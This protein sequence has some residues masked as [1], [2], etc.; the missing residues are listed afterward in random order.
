MDRNGFALLGVLWMVAVVGSVLT[1]GLAPVL[2]QRDGAVNRAALVRA[3]WAAEGCIAL[4]QS[5]AADGR[6]LGAVDSI[7]LG[8]NVWCSLKSLRPDER[9]NVNRADS[10]TLAAALRDPI[11]VA[12]LLDWIDEDDIPREGGAEREWYIDRRRP[13]PRNAPFQDVS[14]VTKVRGFDGAG[15]DDLE[16]V[17]TIW[18]DGTVSP[19]R[20]PFWLLRSVQGVPVGLAEGAVRTRRTIAFEHAEQ[21]VAV[22]GII[23]SIDEF[24][25]MSRHFSFREFEDIVRATGHAETGARRLSSTVTVATRDDEG[26]IGVRVLEVR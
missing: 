19:N 26:R 20:A 8:P 3:Q 21:L 7:A 22:L 5:R 14:E 23:P 4:L 15:V 16:E 9:L 11:R 10:A 12:S 6:Q 24:R 1:T 17:F 25:E 2:A 13:T 18:G